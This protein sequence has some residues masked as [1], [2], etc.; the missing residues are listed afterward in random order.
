MQIGSDKRVTSL[1]IIKRH[2]NYYTNKTKK[3]KE[4]IL[5]LSLNMNNSNKITFI[6]Y[7]KVYI[8]FELNK[9]YNIFVYGQFL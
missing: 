2:C 6:C 9:I 4:I 7:T 3:S 8:N 1:C 5:R